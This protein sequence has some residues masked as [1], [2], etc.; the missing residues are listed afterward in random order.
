MGMRVFLAKNEPPGC[1]GL[2]EAVTGSYAG[3][4]R[5]VLM[6]PRITGKIK[7]M[8]PTDPVIASVEILYSLL[9]QIIKEERRTT[10]CQQ[11]INL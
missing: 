7:N 2:E 6:C 10:T 5:P 1:V 3:S 8:V 11:L 9:Q 4:N